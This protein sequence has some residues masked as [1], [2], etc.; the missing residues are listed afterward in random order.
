[1]ITLDSGLEK[2]F[3]LSMDE[4]NAFTAWYEGKAAVTGPA[5]YSIDNH[6]NNKG[7][8]RSRK[9]YIHTK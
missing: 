9:D 1:M 6:D 7:P 5:S 2:E 3:D 4:V 8:F